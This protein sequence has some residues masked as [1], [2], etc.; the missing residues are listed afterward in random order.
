MKT[1][2]I[3]PAR[4]ASTRFPNKPLAKILGKSML[5]HIVE[6][7]STC[8][9]IDE[10]LVATCDQPIVDHVES[11]GHKA[12]MTSDKHERASDRCAE[13]IAKLENMGSPKFD[14]VIMVQGDEPMTDPRMLSDVL[15]PFKNSS[16]VQVVNLYA[17]IQPGEFNSPNCV[18][19]VMDLA[20]NAMYMSR[21][22]IPVSQDGVE[23]PSGKQL[24]LIAFRRGALAKFAEL[25][26]TP[27]E[28]NESVDMLRFL[29]HGIP[30]RMQRTIY[31][32][33]AV[34]VPADIA[35]V[36]RLMKIAD[37]KT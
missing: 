13:A 19:T 2:A 11:L 12:V 30:I 28:M 5:Q 35:E 1:I 29:E 17:D 24:G 18:K 33:H 25:T 27:L 7:V 6:R 32:T 15:R 9:E 20:G 23:R 3:I 4:L 26:P 36:E 34:D 14:I 10:V 16:E 21:A 8:P 37:L 31:R 22:A